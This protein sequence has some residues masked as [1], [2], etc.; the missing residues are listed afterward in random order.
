M[1]RAD[2]FLPPRLRVMQIIAGALLLG[3]MAF[4]AVALGIV[5]VRTQGAGL[6]PVRNLPMVSLVAVALL[7]V[8]AP[9]AFLVPAFQTRKALRL[10]ASGSEPAPSGSAAVA[11]AT[12]TSALL[13]V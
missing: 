11:V 4:L 12:D 1:S 7:V 2:D 9:L 8:E 6:A 10:I 13:T 3:V 5:F